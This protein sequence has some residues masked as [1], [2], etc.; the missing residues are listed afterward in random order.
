MLNYQRVPKYSMIIGLA[1]KDIPKKMVEE[2]RITGTKNT[3]M[4]ANGCSTKTLQGLISL[5]NYP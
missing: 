2:L 3:Q 1:Q 4:D 5:A